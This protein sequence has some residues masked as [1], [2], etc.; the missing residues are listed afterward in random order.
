MLRYNA[1]MSLNSS[2]IAELKVKHLEMIQALVLRM[3]NQAATIK[4]YCITVTTAVCGLAITLQRPLVALI[5]ILPI[6]TLRC[7]MHSTSGWS[8]A[9]EHCSSG[10]GRRIGG[11]S[12]H[13]RS[14]LSPRPLSDIGGL[15]S[16]G[17]SL[18]FIYHYSPESSSWFS[19]RDAR[20]ASLYN[21]NPFG[22]LA[23]AVKRKAYFAFHY[24]DI[25]RVNNVRNA[26]KISHP[27]S[28]LNRSFYDSSLW[29]SKKLQGDEALKRLI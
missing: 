9:S 15:S 1:F 29:E 17:R 28:D 7:S 4:S 11:R 26:W 6:T 12:L 22:S 10:R 21:P 25:M 5:A 16:V 20:M 18:P 23:P 27:D 19:L 24:D 3:S 13:S 8:G 2:K 14:V